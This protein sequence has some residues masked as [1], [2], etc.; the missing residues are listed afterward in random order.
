MTTKKDYYEILGVPRNATKEEIKRAFRKLARKYHPDVNPNDP[1]AS[2]KFK[3]INAA[4]MILGDDKKR[5]MYDKFGVVDG[6]PGTY[7]GANGGWPGGARVYQGPDGTTYYY[8]TSGGI[9]DFDFSEIFGGSRRSSRQGSSGHGGFDFFND[10]GDIFDVFNRGSASTRARGPR[11]SIPREGEDLR[12]DMEIDFMDAFTGGERQITF[13]DPSTGKPRTI[14]VKIP[15]GVQDG[16]KLR[17]ATLGM[18]GE[19]GGPPGDLYIAVHV[20]PRPGFDRKENDDVSVVAEIPF[21]TAVL[22][23]KVSV[24]G[25]DRTLTVTVPPG[26]KD[27]TTLRLKGQGFTKLKQNERGNLLVDIH[28]QVPDKINSKQ[29]KLLEELRNVGL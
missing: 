12:Y 21:T 11:T 29:R 16:Q 28:V 8:T 23:G 19:N 18:P 10:L 4:Y 14:T 3:E 7:P 15:A 9:P 1:T 25:I 27:G 2:E 24:Q 13:K 26:T 22:G 6:E 20:R 17:L 5:E